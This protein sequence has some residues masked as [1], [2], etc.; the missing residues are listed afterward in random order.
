MQLKKKNLIFFAFYFRIETYDKN[1]NYIAIDWPSGGHILNTK[2]E[3][4]LGTVLY[5][6]VYIV[7]L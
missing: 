5:T 3:Y 1:S 6:Y 4:D 7:A 2:L